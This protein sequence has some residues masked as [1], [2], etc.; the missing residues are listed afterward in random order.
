MGAEVDV[1]FK[2]ELSQGFGVRGGGEE[3]FKPFGLHALLPVLA[4][5]LALADGPAE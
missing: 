2:A 1:F 5:L 3:L 4:F